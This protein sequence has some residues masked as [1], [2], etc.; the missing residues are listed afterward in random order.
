VINHS[1]KIDLPPRGEP[2]EPG[3]AETINIAIDNDG[4]VYWNAFQIDDATMKSRIA[5]AARR[6]PQPELHLRADRRTLYERLAAGDGGGA[7]GRALE[8]SV[9]SLSP[10]MSDK[11]PRPVAATAAPPVAAARPA[12]HGAHSERNASCQGR[13]MIT[14]EHNGRLYQLRRR[15]KA[16]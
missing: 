2:A 1:V 10:D 4:R 7:V 9:S 3:Q 5:E 15:V 8:R 13:D 16:S 14:I 12:D 6:E 11:T